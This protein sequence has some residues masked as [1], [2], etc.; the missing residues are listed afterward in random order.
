MALDAEAGEDYAELVAGVVAAT[1]STTTTGAASSRSWRGRRRRD[2]GRHVHRGDLVELTGIVAAGWRAA[3]GRDW[4]V[5]AG[6]LDWSCA[7]TADH[8]VD[9]VL[10]PAFFLASR[11]LD[12]YPAY[13]ASTPG[14]E[15]SPDELAGALET[16]TRILVAVVADAAAGHPGDHLAAADA[17]DPAPGRLRAPGRPRARPPRPRRRYRAGPRLRPARRAVRPPAPPHDELAALAHAR[18]VAPDARR[19]P[20]GRPAPRLGPGQPVPQE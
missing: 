2:G 11:R 1:M 3:A 18:L 12:A 19:R 14:P 13:G 5:P 4:S 6:T 9:T 8:A 7:R 15:A 10:A 16:A 20:V 17:G